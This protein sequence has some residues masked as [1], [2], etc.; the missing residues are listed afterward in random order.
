MLLK[1]TN[2]NKAHLQKH[3]VDGRNPKQP[4]EKYKNPRI[5]GISTTNLN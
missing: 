2:N 3:T 5:N 1:K 4:P